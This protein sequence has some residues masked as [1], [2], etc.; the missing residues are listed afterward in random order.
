VTPAT[1]P[2]RAPSAEAIALNRDRFSFAVSRHASC[3]GLDWCDCV[4]TLHRNSRFIGASCVVSSLSRCPN[5]TINTA[6]LDAASRRGIKSSRAFIASRHDQKRANHVDVETTRASPPRRAISS[7]SACRFVPKP[8]PIEAVCPL[9]GGRPRQLNR[10]LLRWLAASHH[11]H[12]NHI[13]C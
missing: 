2:S 6:A 4:G 10:T 12:P 11:D 3:L 9:R 1:V 5:A 8:S 13:T 7:L